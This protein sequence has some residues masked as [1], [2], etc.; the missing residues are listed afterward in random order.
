MVSVAKINRDLER[1]NN[2]AKTWHVTFNPNKTYFMK[3]SLKKSSRQYPPIVLNGTI[4]E[5]IKEYTNL[6]LTFNNKMTWESHIT[7]L[8]ERATKRTTTLHRIR[9]KLP[10]PALERIYTSMIRP[11]LE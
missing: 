3:I 6:G 2:W 9:H 8:V 5:E 7:R 1:I 4:I 10:R 11:I